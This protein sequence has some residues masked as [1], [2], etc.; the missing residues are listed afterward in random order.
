MIAI[1]IIIF[2]VVLLFLY[3]A[4]KRSGE[5]SRQ[6]EGMEEINNDKNHRK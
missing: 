3:A 2:L 5:L 6:E 4:C 1:I